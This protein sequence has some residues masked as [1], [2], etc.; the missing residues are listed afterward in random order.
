MLKQAKCR[1]CG[2][3]FDLPSSAPHKKFCS[4]ECRAEWWTERR[5]QGEEELK[6]TKEKEQEPAK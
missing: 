6:R 5:R 3:E 1:Q 4:S 2:E